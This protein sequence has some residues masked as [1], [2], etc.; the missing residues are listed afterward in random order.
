MMT[1]VRKDGIATSILRHSMVVS[2]PAIITPTMTS[3]GEAASIGT[4]SYKGVKNIAAKNS[5]PVVIF[6][7]PVFAP[8]PTPADES[9]KT[10]LEET[11][12]RPPATARSEEHTSEL[13]SRC[14]L[15]CRLLLE[16]H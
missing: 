5:T 8:S 9:A 13:Q 14:H 6:A 10:V 7:R 3:T 2:W 16:K 12:P 15:V 1:M 4:T 11:E